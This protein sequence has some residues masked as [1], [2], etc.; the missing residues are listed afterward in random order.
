MLREYLL[1]PSVASGQPMASARIMMI[2]MDARRM[3]LVRTAH[4]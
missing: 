3:D 1:Q 4:K 2:D